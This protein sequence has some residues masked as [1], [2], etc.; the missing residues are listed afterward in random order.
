MKVSVIIPVYNCEK[1][2]PEL[3][4][5][6]HN[7]TMQD[8]EAIFIDDCSTDET[9]EMLKRAISK[10]KRFHYYRNENRQGAANSRNKGIEISHAPYILCLDADDRF[11]YDLLEQVTDV[12]YA[13]DADMVMLERGDFNGFDTSTIKRDRYL[14]KDEA[15]LFALNVFSLEDQ[16]IDFLLRCENGTCDRM[17]RKKLLDKY[18][19]WFQNL[20]NSND[21]F[22]TVFS[23]FCA[24][25]IVHTSTR[26]NLYH[27]RVHFELGRISN[28]RDPMCAIQA[29]LQI[30]DNLIKY[31]LWEKYCIQFWVFALDSIEKQLFVCKD[32]SR[33][34]EVY[35]YLQ[36]EGLGL[37]GIENDE[38]YISLPQPIK[39]QYSKFK[40]YS[41]EQNCFQK[42]MMLEAMCRLYTYKLKD[43]AD[44]YSGKNCAF[45]GAGRLTSIFIN[46]Y[47]NQNGNF[48]YIIDNDV[49][50]QGADLENIPI[51]SYEEVSNEVE[52]ILVSNRRY[53]G[54]IEAQIR[55]KSEVT[56]IL[57]LEEIIYGV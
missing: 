18:Q 42:S 29:L 8:Y 37:L 31:E 5:C 7:Q 21:I 17:I 40:E 20:K 13:S 45:W 11:E 22:Y 14:F 34:R 48:K 30:H 47:R 28:S 12:A 44:K 16:P 15:Q 54:A 26:D 3:L 57:S 1:F 51:V 35:G 27:R 25:R 46:E 39:E 32:K 6:L 19:I 36:N 55:S 56:E 52:M 49:K 2:I 4:E 41:Y 23:T 43:L 9:P 38:K 50:K 24:K 53:Y 10:D 33:Q